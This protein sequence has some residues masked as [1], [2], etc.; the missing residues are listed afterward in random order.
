MDKKSKNIHK[1]YV[2]AFFIAI[3]Y[4]FV[5]WTKIGEELE[6]AARKKD[7]YNKPVFYALEKANIEDEECFSY[8]IE[9]DKHITYTFKDKDSDF[10]ISKAGIVAKYFTEY[11]TLNADSPLDNYYITLRI[12]CDLH[13]SMLTFLDITNYLNDEYYGKKLNTAIIKRDDEYG[14]LDSLFYS[15]NGELPQIEHV[16][17]DSNVMISRLY[18]DS[19]P[20]LKD[21]DIVYLKEPTVEDF[22]DSGIYISENGKYVKYDVFSSTHG[23]DSELIRDEVLEKQ[24]DWSSLPGKHPY[25]H[26]KIDDYLFNNVYISFNEN[27]KKEI[28]PQLLCSALDGYEP[29]ICIYIL[30]KERI[31]RAVRSWND[32]ERYLLDYLQ[33][34]TWLLIESTESGLY[35]FQGIENKEA[36][37]TSASYSTYGYVQPVIA[38]NSSAELEL[39]YNPD[40]DKM[41]WIIKG[42]K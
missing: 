20:S 10:Y 32:T 3:I 2:F 14:Y 33:P 4:A 27:V 17:V 35:H 15:E 13:K 23:Y 16:V 39:I 26:S 1:L 18:L 37:F 30:S 29:N 21:V 9:S 31:E 12:N 36:V 34:G 42:D 6:K 28:S 11:L 25:R 7:E 19:V 22:L 38:V 5:I 8:K 41:I 40:T 24:M